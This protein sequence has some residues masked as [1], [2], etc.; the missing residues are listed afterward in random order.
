MSKTFDFAK[1]HVDSEAEAHRILNIYIRY[2][3]KK[4]K[5]NKYNHYIF[6]TCP[7]YG[8]YCSHIIGL[9]L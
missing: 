4:F 5:F 2:M 8:D 6:Q 1:F 9:I 7:R 3:L